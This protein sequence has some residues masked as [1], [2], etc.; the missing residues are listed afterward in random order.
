MAAYP[1]TDDPAALARKQLIDRGTPAAPPTPPAVPDVSGLDD[2]QKSATLMGHFDT[3]VADDYFA[4]QPPERQERIRNNFYAQH[5]GGLRPGADSFNMDPDLRVKVAQSLPTPTAVK[6]LADVQ[7]QAAPAETAAPAV[8][9][10]GRT[11]AQIILGQFADS[12]MPV[13]SMAFGGKML[14]GAYQ[15]LARS[16][17]GTGKTVGEL[18]VFAANRLPDGTPGKETVRDAGEAVS[19]YYDKQLEAYAPSDPD[20]RNGVNVVDKPELLLN[21][22]YWAQGVGEM[23]GEIGQMMIT[24][25]GTAAQAMNSVGQKM[26]NVGGRMVPYT[27]EVA[28]RAAQFGAAIMGGIFGGVKEGIMGT[29]GD[30]RKKEGWTE[31]QAAIAG[32]VQGA[33]TVG[34]NAIGISALLKK[35]PA[36]SALTQGFSRILSAGT[37]AATETA[38]GG[39]DA[40]AKMLAKYLTGESPF[41][42]D[43]ADKIVQGVKDEVNV[44]GPAFLTGLLFGGGGGVEASSKKKPSWTPAETPTSGEGALTKREAVDYIEKTK[45]EVLSRDTKNEVKEQ[46][47]DA[48]AEAGDDQKA[49]AA[50]VADEL[51]TTGAVAP[52][53]ANEWKQAEQV[54]DNGGDFLAR[55]ENEL[56]AKETATAQTPALPSGKTEADTPLQEQ[57]PTAQAPVAPELTPGVAERAQELDTRIAN[58]TAS[59]NRVGEDNPQGQRF[60][61]RRQSFEAEKATLLEQA[62]RAQEI[63]QQTQR[64][65]EAGLLT[66]EGQGPF[67]P[68]RAVPLEDAAAPAPQAPRAAQDIQ[69]RSMDWMDEPLPREVQDIDRRI[70]N[71]GSSVRQAGGETPLGQRLA[72]KQQELSAERNALL[73]AL[74]QEREASTAP[75]LRTPGAQLRADLRT[76]EAVSQLPSGEQQAMPQVPETP[77]ASTPELQAMRQDYRRLEDGSLGE[78]LANARPSDKMPPLAGMSMKEL[79]QEAKSLGVEVSRSLSNE[80]L[81]GQ[82]EEARNLMGRA[83]R[84]EIEARAQAEQWGRSEKARIKGETED[85]IVAEVM[86]RV[87]PG[88][89]TPEQRKA[90][91]SKYGPG[92]FSK[93]KRLEDGSTYNPG[94]GLDQLEMEGAIAHILP[95]AYGSDNLFTYLTESGRGTTAAAQAAEADI[96]AAVERMAEEWGE[97]QKAPRTATATGPAPVTADA[98]VEEY[99]DARD[100]VPFHRTDKLGFFSQMGEVLEKPG[101]LPKVAKTGAEMAAVIGKHQKSGKFKGEELADS[102]IMEW[103]AS[104]GGP[105]TRQDV[106][107]EIQVRRVEVKEVV[108]GGD[109]EYVKTQTLHSFNINPA[110][111]EAILGGQPLYQKAK[112][113]TAGSTV[114]AIEKAIKPLLVRLKGIADRVQVVQSYDDLPVGLYAAAKHANMIGGFDAVYWQGDIYLVADAMTAEEARGR[115]LGFILGHEG[116]H[117]VARMLFPDPAKRHEFFSAITKL[118]PEKVKAYLDKHGLKNTEANRIMAAEEV[119]VDMV[120]ESLASMKGALKFRMQQFL[121]K[122]R[123]LLAQIMPERFEGASDQMLIDFVAGARA[124]IRRDGD[125]AYG[126][127][128]DAAYMRKSEAGA[129]AKQLQDFVAGKLPRGEVLTVGTT[130]KV[131]RILGAKKLKLV[132]PQRNAAKILKDKHKLPLETLKDIP[133]AIADPVMVFD[134]ATMADSFVILTDLMVGGKPVLSAIHLNVPERHFSVNEVA[135]VYGKDEGAKWVVA[136]ISGGR[137]RYQNKKKASELRKSGVLQL[138]REFAVR[139]K[140]KIFTEA[141]LVNPFDE[142]NVD[143]LDFHRKDAERLAPNGKPAKLNAVQYA[144]VQAKEFKD[145]FGDWEKGEGS[146]VLDENGE[147]LV[148]YHGT[149]ADFS[150]FKNSDGFRGFYFTRDPA[151]AEMKTSLANGRIMPVYLS[152]KNPLILDGPRSDPGTKSSLALRD[153]DIERLKRDG[154]DGIINTTYNEIVAFEPTQIKSATGNSGQFSKDNDDI[155]F[156][157]KPANHQDDHDIA[158]DVPPSDWSSKDGIKKMLTRLYA[159]LVNRDQPVISL[160]ATAG[161]AEKDAA[162]RQVGRMRGLGGIT[163]EILAGKGIPTYWRDGEETKQHTTMSLKDI[164][165]QLGNRDTQYNYEVLRKGERMLALA[166]HRPELTPARK[167]QMLADIAYVKA[168]YGATPTAAELKDMKQHIQDIRDS[169]A[170]GVKG[171][172]EALW[173]KHL[174]DLKAKIGDAEYVRLQ[175]ISRLHRKFEREAILRP[176]V[177]SGIMSKETYDAIIHA[178]E[179]EYYS[180]FAREMDDV[181]RQ[182]IG[183]KEVVKRI[184]GSDKRTLP[185]IESTIANIERTVRLVEQQKLHRN[186]RDLKD[187]TPDLAEVIKPVKAD[188]RFPPKNAFLVYED[189]KKK[190]YTAPADVLNALQGVHPEEANFAMKLLMPAARMLRAGATLTLEFVG[191]NMIRDQ[192]SAFIYSKWGYIPYVDFAKGLFHILGDTDM[193]RRYRTA[194]AEQSYFI[195][196]DRQFANVTAEDLVSKKPRYIKYVKNP[197]EALRALSELSEKPTRMGAFARAKK[198][199]ATDIEAALEARDV[200]LDF[201]RMGSQ[202]RALNAIIPFWNAHVQD[203]DKTTRVFKDKP[204][205]TLLKLALASTLPAVI[206]WALQHDDDRYKELPEWRKNLFWNI[207]VGEGKDAFV[208]SLPKTFFF[209]AIFASLVE[210]ILDYTFLNDKEAI[211][212]GL[213]NLGV[214][215]LPGVN[216]TAVTPLIENMSNFSWFRQA[217]L[218]S[219]SLQN[220]PEGMRANAGTSVWATKIGGMIN[221]SPIKLD[222]LRR[223]WTGG[224]GGYVSDAIDVGINAIAPGSSGEAVGKNWYEAPLVKGFISGNPAING[225]SVEKF[226]K[227]LQNTQQTKYGLSALRKSG[228]LAEAARFK[229]DNDKDVRAAAYMDSTAQYLSALN[230]QAAAAR[231]S[232][233]LSSTEKRIRIEEIQ[234][235]MTERAAKANDWYDALK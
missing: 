19:N 227:T 135:S 124:A 15:G 147:P 94:Q 39:T 121:A 198:N 4:K 119:A 56:D 35:L 57:A 179:N 31:E 183:D 7:A 55:L 154:Y 175:R 129:W 30:L 48:L 91:A 165:S 234:T 95:Q 83:P 180:S 29:Y 65:R 187:L 107:D 218:E 51:V 21:P 181:E 2:E 229:A 233:D 160:A 76:Q 208:F 13:N 141:D 159:K 145:W 193:Y 151:Y 171:V 231:N 59:I 217:P 90:L 44:A 46:I 199:G 122:L 188:P 123:K 47:I 140:G 202:V 149:R 28:E 97:R 127:T 58:L 163:N 18:G 11:A 155:R 232:K 152:I 40:Y 113:S 162:I 148:V 176:L 26:V 70:Q 62:A 109:P 41:P 142:E 34:L 20:L 192:K 167:Q 17:I 85:P 114:A 230:K 201:S 219:R 102:G 68:S 184:K 150:T 156:H 144:Q 220:L 92:I 73:A 52:E 194:G 212:E 126:L 69:D 32:T 82:I 174:A 22:E 45:Q 153:N 206:L 118:A 71:L 37:E 89:V 143:G 101:M 33:S 223:G 99:G 12:N 136:Q 210:R 164:L 214:M 134:S 128:E 225:K 67:E 226:Y 185:S 115:Y 211:G 200:T 8:P 197:I 104:I 84:N 43:W 138:H 209:D 63:S 204:G 117:H 6:P 157:R 189:G 182:V 27:K 166:K 222:N 103:L 130:P 191:R 3:H 75:E 190:Y 5:A 9:Q 78:K 49:K 161:Q 111:R 10:T 14:H 196:L 224:L 74:A 132:M 120:G 158:F 38:E 172:D 36:G 96:D 53:S 64:A 186:L 66:D 87:H 25:A 125:V 133:R 203:A 42:Q 105:V 79:R 228:N 235:K 169:Y 108:K 88:K 81:R 131:L 216:V 137:L 50:P 77:Q 112:P 213:R 110:M 106:L 72:A 221:V 98:K 61:A 168:L 207:V 178:P 100:D 195:S 170:G 139:G 116:G 205:V 1:Q 16:S 93:N 146:K 80:D 215:A 177:E 86:G 60:A 24:G 173:A 23:G 54:L